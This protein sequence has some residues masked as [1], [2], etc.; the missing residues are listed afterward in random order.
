F[1]EGTLNITDENTAAFLQQLQYGIVKLAEVEAFEKESDP[2]R[3]F[4]QFFI[5][6]DARRYVSTFPDIDVTE[7]LPDERWTGETNSVVSEL[8][9]DWRRFWKSEAQ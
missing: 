2:H 3:I 5:D 6:F 8:P 1:R 9:E 7:Y 4:P